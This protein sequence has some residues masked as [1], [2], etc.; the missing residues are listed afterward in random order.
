M[1]VMSLNNRVKFASKEMLPATCTSKTQVTCTSAPIKNTNVRNQGYTN[2]EIYDAIMAVKN[3][4]LTPF[5]S[6]T[7]PNHSINYVI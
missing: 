7:K 2:E 3:F 5:K 6:E 4:V 1:K